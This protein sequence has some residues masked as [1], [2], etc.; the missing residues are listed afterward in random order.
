[1]VWGADPSKFCY[2]IDSIEACVCKIAMFMGELLGSER[3]VIE[4]KTN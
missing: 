1:M 3:E 2:Y 4:N